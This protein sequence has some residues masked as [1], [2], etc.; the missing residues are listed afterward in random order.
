MKIFKKVTID[1]IHI[2]IGKRLKEIPFYF[3]VFILGRILY[4]FLNTLVMQILILATICYYVLHRFWNIPY[5]RLHV[6]P[7]GLL[8]MIVTVSFEEL[9]HAGV[10][11]QKGLAE[12]VEFLKI[13][14]LKSKSGRRIAPGYASIV[15]KNMPV[16][17]NLIYIMAG[18]SISVILLLISVFL[19]STVTGNFGLNSYQNEIR[20]YFLILLLF[21]VSSLIP[22][23]IL[24]E[25]DGAK[26]LKLRKSLSMSY[27]T[28]LRHLFFSPYQVILYLFGYKIKKSRNSDS[29]FAGHNATAFNYFQKG[30]Y[31]EA[32]DALEMAYTINPGNGDVCNNLAYCYLKLD[33]DMSRA[34]LLAYKAVK[35]NKNDATYLETLAYIMR[36]K[37]DIEKSQDIF[38][39]IEYLKRGLE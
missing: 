8:M 26:I 30:M 14:I 25:S 35:T 37:G 21:H 31:K 33:M 3:Y 39:R 27:M 19:V 23:N 10:A 17:T 34:L 15:F 7:I 16:S 28:L 5:Y 4:Y 38:K 32:I 20:Y 24:T 13:A 12:N 6:L 29:Q 22:T 18:G 1:F 2:K 11:I 9:F 36:K